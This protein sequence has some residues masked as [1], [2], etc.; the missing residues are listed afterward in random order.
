[1][2]GRVVSH[3]GLFLIL[4]ALLGA[5]AGQ[6]GP[7]SPVPTAPPT[8]VPTVAATVAPSTVAPTALPPT[9]V[10][11]SPPPSATP[12]GAPA[13]QPSATAEATRIEFGSGMTYATLSGKLPAN[14]V[15]RYVLRALEGQVMEVSVTPEQGIQLSIQGA[16][17]TIL[18]RGAG[19]PFFRGKL[20]STQ[21]YVMTLVGG[22]QAVAFTLDVII[23][24]RIQFA[25]GSTSAVIEGQLPA[26]GRH[27]YVLGIQAKQI[28][29][30]DVSPP[31]GLRTI[32]YGV[33]GTVLKSG[34]GE[35]S[36][37]RG[38]V[39]ITQDYLLVI[40][41]GDQASAYTMNVI[42]PA[43]IS[44]AAGATSGMVEG[45]LAAH[46][47]QYYVLG[48]QANQLMEVDVTS[49]SQLQLVI[50]GVDG[51]VLK[52][53]MGGGAF[54]RGT[55]PSTQ[56]YILI[57]SSGDQA[58]SYTMSVVIPRRIRFAPGAI[59]AVEEGKVGPGQERSYVLAAGGGQTMKIDVVAPGADV[60]LVIYGEDGTVLK[61]GMGG[62]ATF[63][64]TLPSTQ[65]YWIV[66][67][68]ADR[69]TSY[70]LEVTIQ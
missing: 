66:V 19:S 26:H 57:L 31:S 21:D 39:P 42:I 28:M 34:M 46:S 38:E 8:A 32:I 65:D 44:F 24:E 59:S 7:T 27:Y 17:G 63:E 37:F 56:D 36:F 61:S 49:Q 9:S 67:G 1:M 11:T 5:C 15:A 35:G 14:G 3:L 13:A 47:S 12:T 45:R 6:G 60:R 4:V 10:P 52:S 22:S 48:A 30:V 50:Y 18:K 58:A 62:G 25:A 70:Q 23:P 29:E 68:P 55:L 33:D 64:G 20:P 51:T 2:T 16:D 54:F 41:T 69:S 40:E 43:R 53:G